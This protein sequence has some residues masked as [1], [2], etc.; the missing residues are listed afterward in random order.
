MHLHGPC[1]LFLFL[2]LNGLMN[3]PGKFSIA[4]AFLGNHSRRPACPGA[5]QL[6]SGAV[7]SCELSSLKPGNPSPAQ[8]CLLGSAM[9][10]QGEQGRR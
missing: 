10:P 1:L 4:G 3:F 2:F 8:V 5:A 7:S 9:L 6:C